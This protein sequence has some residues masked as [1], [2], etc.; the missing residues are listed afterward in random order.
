MGHVPRPR[1]HSACEEWKENRESSPRGGDTGTEGGKAGV[2]CLTRASA[3]SNQKQP[4]G[5][6][7]D[8][9]SGFHTLITFCLCFFFSCYSR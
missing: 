5:S 8:Y 6:K 4:K 7:T 1:G 2:H 9:A 3:R